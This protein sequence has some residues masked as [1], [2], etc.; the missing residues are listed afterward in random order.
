[1]YMR[2]L[3]TFALEAEFAP[4]RKLRAFRRTARTQH[5]VLYESFQGEHH[6][7]VAL[8]G[9]GTAS[10]TAAL[11]ELESSKISPHVVISSGL[12]GA[13]SGRL[14]IGDLIAPKTTRSLKNDAA[15]QSDVLLLELAAS[16]GAIVVETM[17]TANA[18]VATAAEKAQLGFFGDAVEMESTT[19]LSHFARSS[20]HL[21]AFRA[22]SDRAD[23]DLPLD[24][25]RCL[26]AQ[27]SVKPLSLL[28][29][30]VRRP[31]NLPRVIAFGKQ[32]HLAAQKLADALESFVLALPKAL[33]AA[34]A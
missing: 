16:H 25:D 13:L 28:N 33:E 30:I 27:G 18:L 29:Q 24:F 15:A 26:T 4:W 5:A 3:V 8:T 6:V 17:I 1:M 9:M 34:V 7:T 11:R 21:I 2:I 19:I 31:G 10:A 22:V 14:S 32:S 20:A 12:A 23:E